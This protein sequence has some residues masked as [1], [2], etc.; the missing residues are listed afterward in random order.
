MNTSDQPGVAS[1]PPT[2]A[3]KLSLRAVPPSGPG[4][5]PAP[6]GGRW[7]LE[8][9]IEEPPPRGDIDLGAN[10]C[11]WRSDIDRPVLSPLDHHPV[12]DLEGSRTLE[13]ADRRQSLRHADRAWQRKHNEMMRGDGRH[14]VH[15]SPCWPDQVRRVL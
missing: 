8:D 1:N 14:G 9:L 10:S 11:G 6:P 4:R 3:T 13:P 7:T 2:S 5:G 15:L 12:E